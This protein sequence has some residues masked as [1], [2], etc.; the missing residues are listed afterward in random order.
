MTSSGIEPATF[1][2]VAKW[3]NQLR[4]RVPLSCT[5]V[6]PNLGYANSQGYEPGHFGVREKKKKLNDDRKMH[7]SSYS[8]EFTV[9]IHK[10]EITATI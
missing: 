8:L 2:P 7:V 6:I 3:L 10:S 5:A 1:R 4:H 9:T